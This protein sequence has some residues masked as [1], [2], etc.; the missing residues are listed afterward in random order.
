MQY[1]PNQFAGHLHPRGRLRRYREVVQVLVRH[2]FDWF[3]RQLGLTELA[4]LRWWILR[5]HRELT[6]TTAEHLR[7][8]MEELGVTFI[9]LGQILSTRSDLLPPDYVEELT[10]LQEE[11]PPERYEVVEA[12]VTRELGRPPRDLFAEFDPRPSGSASIGQVH[13]ARL[14][15]GENVVVKIQRPGLHALVEEDLRIMRDMARLAAGRTIWGQVYDLPGLVEEFASTLSDELNYLQEGRNADRIRR[16]FEN[17][18]CLRVPTIYWGYTTRKVLVMERIQGIHI[19]DLDAL[20]AAG[21]DRRQLAETG[22]RIVLK[23][24]LEDGFYHADPHPGNFLVLEDGVLGL[25]DFGMVGQ[26]D[27]STK[28]GLVYLLLAIVNQDM[29]RVVD[30]LMDLGLVGNSV[31]L[32]RLRRDLGRLLAEY[33]GLPLREIDVSRVLDESMQV[34]RKHRLRV[35]T[36][37][38]LLAKTISMNEAIA[39]K[40]DPDF[41]AAEVLRQYVPQLVASRYLPG[42]WSRGVLPNLL[43]L[44]RLASSLPRRADRLLTRVEHGNITVNISVQE[45]DRVIAALNSVANRLIL[46]M[47][48]GSF[49]V[50]I[51][52][53]VQVYYTGGQRW[54]LGWALGIGMAVVTGLGLWLAY[55]ILR[56]GS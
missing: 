32:E 30:R 56:K 47:L 37:L 34:I 48:A 42:N 39:R 50:A 35:P 8:A 38:V 49:A 52:L 28:E 4:P 29:D 19:G 12:E 44:G 26:V 36:H 13:A 41:S 16:S 5:G 9:K 1:H 17:D 27:E 24:A 10:R 43:D 20:E 6:F 31:Q 51:A 7:R 23:M 33:W 2:G 46:G 14:V 54:I 11:V 3:I 25:M 53:L 40:L 15:S 45:T 22:A 18:P 21:I 55:N